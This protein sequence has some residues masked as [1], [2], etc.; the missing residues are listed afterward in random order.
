MSSIANG[1][2]S[3]DNVGLHSRQLLEKEMDVLIPKKDQVGEAMAE[4]VAADAKIGTCPSCGKDLLIKHS[5]KNRSSFIGC[6]GW[7]A[8]GQGC[9]VTYPLPPGKIEAVEEACAVCGS[10]QIKVIQFR[11]KPIVRC[12]DPNCSSN[13]EPEI[14]VGECPVCKAAGN[15]GRLIARR[16][17][18]SLKRFIR[19]SNYDQCS[20]SYPL[21]QY[22]ELTATNKVC[23]ACGAPKVVVQTRRGGWE[24]CPNPACPLRAEQDAGRATGA[25]RAS[26]R[27]GAKA[28][29]ASGKSQKRGT[30]SQA[31]TAKA[32]K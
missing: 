17:P 4:A 32:K 27:T 7:Q 31:S 19:C 25:K 30:R 14:D 12:V 3:R 15:T 16:S 24:L 5:A 11:Q 21:P 6:S 18:K 8:D 22:G 1:Q 29:A 28:K 26:T 20:T 2:D 10:P 13:Q 9:N 23:E